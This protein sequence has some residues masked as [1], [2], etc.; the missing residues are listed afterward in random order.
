MS[1]LRHY[2][3]WLLNKPEDELTEVSAELD[4]RTVWPSVPQ[5][6]DTVAA[7]IRAKLAAG[8]D[9]VPSPA[10]LPSG[11]LPTA[12]PLPAAL[13]DRRVYLACDPAAPASAVL[14]ESYAD[15]AELARGWGG[16]IVELPLIADFRQDPAQQAVLR[17]RRHEHFSTSATP[18][19]QPVVIEAVDAHAGRL[20]VTYRLALP[21]QDEGQ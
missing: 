4:G 19:I 20:T 6:A 18:P 3:A 12:Q 15:A 8:P 11:Y 21:G 13:P 9:P 5:D 10:D 1:L 7:R 17:W 2:A 14:R 16:V